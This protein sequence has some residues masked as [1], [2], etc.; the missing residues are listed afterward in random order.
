MSQYLN[1]SDIKYIQI[2]GTS[3]CNLVCPQCARVYKGKV[4]PHLPMGELQPEDYDK[5]FGS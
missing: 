2:E 3:L 5:I 1:L 4:N